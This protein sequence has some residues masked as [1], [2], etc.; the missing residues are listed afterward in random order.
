MDQ[1]IPQPAILDVG[2]IFPSIRER[3]HHAL[4]AHYV[5]GDILNRP[6]QGVYIIEERVETSFKMGRR[7]II[8]FAVEDLPT[9]APVW[10]IEANRF[11]AAT[12]DYRTLPDD[13]FE[14]YGGREAYKKYWFEAMRSRLRRRGAATIIGV[15]SSN[16]RSWQDDTWCNL[17]YKLPD[18]DQLFNH[19][20]GVRAVLDDFSEAISRK[21]FFLQES[22]GGLLR[23][24]RVPKGAL[25]EL[26][27]VK[28]AMLDQAE[29]RVVREMNGEL[30][31]VYPILLRYGD[32]C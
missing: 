18:T 4:A 26:L 24:L 11:L 14:G 5:V 16:Y 13:A 32:D 30:V 31:T 23:D 8:E 1:Y 28:E 6:N 25:N 15:C 19:F 3:V 7:R 22:I 20:Q 29:F 2:G 21:D 27:R 12:N 17:G 10:Q 9:S